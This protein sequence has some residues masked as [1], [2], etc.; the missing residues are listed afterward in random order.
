M[1]EVNKILVTSLYNKI[2]LY[3]DIVEI[4]EYLQKEFLSY[5]KY[6]KSNTESMTKE[7]IGDFNTFVIV[8]EKER[9]EKVFHKVHT[10]DE[11]KVSCDA[12]SKEVNIDK[13]FIA[14]ILDSIEKNI[15][16][17]LNLFKKKCELEVYTFHMKY[18]EKEIYNELNNYVHEDI[19][20][21]LDRL[22]LK[23]FDL[24]KAVMD[25]LD[26]EIKSYHRFIW[27]T[28]K[29]LIID[30]KKK[31]TL[32]N[33]EIEDKIIIKEDEVLNFLDN[34][35]EK[36]EI[37]V[38]EEFIDVLLNLINE[39][40]ED[41]FSKR[42]KIYKKGL[43]KYL[44]KEISESNLIRR[45]LI[46]YTTIDDIAME[47]R[48]YAIGYNLFSIEH[49]Y[50]SMMLNISKFSF[51]E[52]TDEIK[53]SINTIFYNEFF[54]L[55]YYINSEEEFY[56]ICRSFEDKFNYITC[57][58]IKFSLRCIKN[59]Y[60][61]SIIDM[62]MDNIKSISHMNIFK[63]IDSYVGNIKIYN[64]G[65]IMDLY[66]EWNKIYDNYNNL[67]KYCIDTS[68]ILIL[69]EKD[70]L[71]EYIHLNFKEEGIF[72]GECYREFKELERKKEE[73]Y[74]N[75]ALIKE[76]LLKD[77]EGDFTTYFDHLFQSMGKNL[78]Y[79]KSEEK[80]YNLK[81]KSSNK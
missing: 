69:D 80:H 5:F 30:L 57:E 72:K 54:R 3:L 19:E 78:E 48:L 75:I 37:E 32:N 66:D 74:N 35:K 27:N 38:K 29:E 39:A 58:I 2:N 61:N 59:D 25:A 28:F 9:I 79:V 68:N 33:G 26:E 65:L 71:K 64:Q 73:L 7:F 67:K 22:K 52:M 81:I 41:E 4:F 13:E 49:D 50:L 62:L 10:S 24:K 63:S 36:I 15:N 76:K 18:N 21:A 23:I 14:N 70:F 31:D 77:L 16:F 12:L 34:L 53:L 43:N 45:G 55:I 56:T 46:E 17:K 44:A 51:D 20:G 60:Y 1:E 40:F 47:N 42:I 11:H 8:E 6:D